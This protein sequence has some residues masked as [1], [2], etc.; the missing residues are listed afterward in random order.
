MDL[1]FET[2]A[3]NEYAENTKNDI[4]LEFLKFI[5]FHKRN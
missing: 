2:A 5:E 4:G 3:A 1:R